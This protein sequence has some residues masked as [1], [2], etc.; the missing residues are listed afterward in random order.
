MKLAATIA[1]FLTPLIVVGFVFLIN[2]LFSRFFG[3]TN[4]V[5][6]SQAKE[7]VLR[8]SATGLANFYKK[9]NNVEMKQQLKKA[10][11]KIGKG[12]TF[13]ESYF[14]DKPG[15]KRT[16]QTFSYNYKGLKS[17]LEQEEMTE[18]LG[19]KQNSSSEENS[20]RSMFPRH[21]EHSLF[22]NLLGEGTRDSPHKDF[23]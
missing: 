9:T 23:G 16:L 14:E 1:S 20:G 8:K 2:R 22:D 12:G 15:I 11:N 19:E 6:V 10:V 17:Q 7:T 21:Q 13:D 5:T 4:K 18:I 3:K